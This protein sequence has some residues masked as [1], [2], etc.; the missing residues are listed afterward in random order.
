MNVPSK[1]SRPLADGIK[2]F[3][4]ILTQMRARDVSDSDA[5]EPIAS[6]QTKAMSIVRLITALVTSV[7]VVGCALPIGS[8]VTSFHSFGASSSPRGSIAIVPAQ[9]IPDGLEFRNYAGLV[10]GWLQTKGLT[11]AS[12]V[13]SADYIG[14][15]SY[16][17][18]TGREQISSTPIV[19]QTGGGTAFTTGTYGS[20]TTYS[21]PT[22]GVVGSSASS[23]M[24]YTR[25][26][27][28]TIRDRKTRQ[29]VWEGRNRSAGV[30]G[31]I[32]GVLPTMIKAMLQEFPN[33]SGKT[34]WVVLYE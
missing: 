8:D 27:K 24:I 25:V 10:L 32:A 33:E 23:E 31:E 5:G 11:P 26:A 20:A 34:K 2:K 19:G 22:F 17:I 3:Q 6:A 21:P 9:G 14:T 4:P 1:V 29:V 7:L 18:D 12:S 16:S 13:G 30:I 15:F 28:L